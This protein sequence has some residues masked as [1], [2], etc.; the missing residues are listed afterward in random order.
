MNMHKIQ[1]IVLWVLPEESTREWVL[2]NPKRL[3]KCQHKDWWWALK[4]YFPVEL[5]L[6]EGS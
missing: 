3:E 4:M 6:K 5:R 2:K 1:D